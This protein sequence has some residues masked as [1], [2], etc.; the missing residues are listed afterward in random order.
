VNGQGGIRMSKKKDEYERGFTCSICEQKC[1]DKDGMY[2]YYDKD[3]SIMV[4]NTHV[5]DEKAEARYKPIERKRYHK[6][7]T[8]IRF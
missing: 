7:T 8:I 3:K 4:C 1:L 6:L 5:R 2:L